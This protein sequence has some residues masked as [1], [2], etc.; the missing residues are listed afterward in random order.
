MSWYLLEEKITMFMIVFLLRGQWPILWLIFS[1]HMLI[2]HEQNIVWQFKKRDLFK[3]TP[4]K[5]KLSK[6]EMWANI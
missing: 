2:F 3:K 1:R 6:I 5:Y 4:M